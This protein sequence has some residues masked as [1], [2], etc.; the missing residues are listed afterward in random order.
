MATWLMS[1]KVKFLIK[2]KSKQ[3]Q[4]CLEKK[5]NKQKQIRNERF[6]QN[7]HLEM[8]FFWMCLVIVMVFRNN[9][10]INKIANKN[11]VSGF[12]F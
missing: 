4:T 10:C 5:M 6:L 1:H 8:F 3:K 2:T 7:K 11:H 12:F 9:I